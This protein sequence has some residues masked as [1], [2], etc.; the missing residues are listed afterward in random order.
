MLVEGAFA[1]KKNQLS[2]FLQH[3]VCCASDI[4][5]ENML[6]LSRMG[7]VMI[8][9][10]PSFYNHPKTL[11]EMVDHIVTRVLDQFGLETPNA[12]RWHRLRELD[13]VG[14]RLKTA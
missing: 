5:L 7:A 8:P 1:R 14:K 13:S 11:A 2:P 9:P 10:L 6:A 3:Y 12:A 4:H